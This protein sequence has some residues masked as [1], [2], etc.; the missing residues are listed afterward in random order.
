MKKGFTIV[1]VL[2]LVSVLFTAGTYVGNI[3]RLCNCDFEAPYK[4]E[5]IYGAGIFTPTFLATAFLDIE[6]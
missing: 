1:G 4:A 5:I 3:V 2:I 6:D